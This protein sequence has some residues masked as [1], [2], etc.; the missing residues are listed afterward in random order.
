MRNKQNINSTQ[1]MCVLAGYRLRSERDAG[2]GVEN[3][4]LE[5]EPHMDPKK[6][7]A[8]ETMS[9][10]RP[11]SVA[12]GGGLVG[13]CL[14]GDAG[15]VGEVGEVVDAGV[16]EVGEETDT[17]VGLPMVGRGAAT[18]TGRSGRE[19]LEN[20]VRDTGA[21]VAAEGADASDWL[22]LLIPFACG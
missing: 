1:Q 10:A 14:T 16:G 4:Q 20:D 5:L 22:G 9:A 21:G 3:L 15:D 7:L 18:E 11:T 19:G 2:C 12:S 17:L 8:D 6:P 13:L